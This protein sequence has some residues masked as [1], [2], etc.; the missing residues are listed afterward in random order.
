M[1]LRQL[2]YFIAVAEDS[3][4][5]RAARRAYV[6]QQA[7]SKAILSLEEELGV[8]LFERYHSGVALTVYGR[9]LIKR[10]YQI[11]NILNQARN[12]LANLQI[13]TD[14][15][16]QV[17]FTEGVEDNFPMKVL[18]GFQDTYPNYSVFTKQVNDK[19]AEDGL[20]SEKYDLGIV[21]ALGN[22]LL[23]DYSL[24]LQHQTFVV[25]NKNN[26]LSRRKSLRMEDLKNEDLIFCGPSFNA[27][28][29][30]ISA[31]NLAGFTPR[32]RHYTVSIS[33]LVELLHANQG[34]YLSPDVLPPMKDLEDITLIPIEND[35]HIFSIYIAAKRG[36]E[37]NEGCKLLVNRLESAFLHANPMV[38]EI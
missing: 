16:I 5:S 3:S 20:I 17:A 10:A 33:Y 29:R 1:E 18:F 13:Q 19:D 9:T 37:L 28:S 34:I 8:P 30:L 38:D 12:E 24:L 7:M 36:R 25:I 15:I 23:I 4:F 32:F 14:Q 2:Q 35:P 11:V 22:S 27:N 6:S 26:P 21:G 31:C